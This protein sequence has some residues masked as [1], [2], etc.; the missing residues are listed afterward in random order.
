LEKRVLKRYP[1]VTNVG[2]S[3]GCKRCDNTRY[4]GR[5]PIMEIL[6]FDKNVDDM[7]LRKA[8][9]NEFMNYIKKVGLMSMADDAILK[10]AQGLTTLD[11]VSK[12]IDM[13]DYIYD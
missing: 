1:K 11:E 3:K 6:P 2:D 13:S 10:I 5:T 7:I 8:S 4:Y 9:R 12:V